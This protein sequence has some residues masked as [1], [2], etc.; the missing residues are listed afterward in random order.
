MT[1]ALQLFGATAIGVG[2]LG[3]YLAA[4]RRLGWLV[5]IASTVMWRPALT[6][7]RQWAAVAN[8]GLSIAIC[9]RN[10]RATSG[11]DAPAQAPGSS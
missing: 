11:R 8:C 10:Y 5:C 7:G 4:Q 6:Q 2:L 3:T 9:L 1:A